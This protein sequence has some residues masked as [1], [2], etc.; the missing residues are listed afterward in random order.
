MRPHLVGPSTS[1]SGYWL[2]AR[3]LRAGT[4]AALFYDQAWL[5]ARLAAHGL[6]ADTMLG[7][8]PLA[9]TLLP[10]S[11]LDHD[12]ARTA[13]M[14]FLLPCLLLSL[15]LL[16]RRLPLAHGLALA[17]A[18]TLGQPSRASFEVAQVYPL[19]LLLHVLAVEGWRRG[20]PI[21]GM[22]L[23]P[24]ILLRG[25]HGLPQAFGWLWAGRPL[26]LLW[27]VAGVGLGA[28]LSLPLLGLE[29]WRRF[30]EQARTAP[31]SS[32]TAGALA[33]QTWRSLALRLST[34]GPELPDPALPGW[35]PWLYLSGACL[36]LL[37]TAWA[38]RRL[39]RPG[40][41]L[42]FAA[43]T[44]LAL[45]LAPFAEDHHFLLAAVPA[46]LLWEE[47]PRRRGLVLLALLLILPAWGFDRPELW[48]GW[49]S[50][51]GYPRVWGMALLLGALVWEGR[52]RV[53]QPSLS[54]PVQLSPI[55]T[56]A[57]GRLA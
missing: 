39:D 3:E 28:L 12:P 23:S 8:P 33:Y 11:G 19:L 21:G 36:V 25:W 43:W 13:W 51:A 14:I 17:A 45:L 2:L 53:A 54:E 30:A 47:A 24:L 22:A 10:W 42:P 48:G 27:T 29:S 15:W 52:N 31:F 44:V 9:L 35:H 26:G 56:L 41:G 40:S 49:R 34:T 37:A 38:A 50:L 55:P 5:H 32:E 4:D 16:G 57:P 6:P 46:F 1:F 18:F 7:P 20:A